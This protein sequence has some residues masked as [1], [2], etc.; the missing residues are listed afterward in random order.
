[1]GDITD[2]APRGAE[3]QLGD[4]VSEESQVRCI[5]DH[6]SSWSL[7]WPPEQFGNQ[8]RQTHVIFLAR[9]IA[10]SVPWELLSLQTQFFNR[11]ILQSHTRYKGQTQMIKLEYVS[12]S[13]LEAVINWLHIGT[14]ANREWLK[15][16]SNLLRIF[17]LAERWEMPGLK[18]FCF[19]TMI[20][21]SFRAWHYNSSESLILASN[22]AM[23][24]TIQFLF[25]WEYLRRHH[26]E[27]DELIPI[28]KRTLGEERLL[29]GHFEF[30]SAFWTIRRRRE[31]RA[32][33]I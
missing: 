21:I 31:A 4:M 1:M 30:A 17:L 24:S 14:L 5:T 29:C 26:E 28:T 18:Q 6:W 20:C 8:E 11:E 25:S 33:L 13:D 2:W 22:R 15:N 19:R 3:G 27:G 23:G 16:T 32:W 12:P 7:D 10:F 9:E